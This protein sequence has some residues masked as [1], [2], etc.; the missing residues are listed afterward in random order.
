MRRAAVSGDGLLR[1]V[2]LTAG[3]VAAGLLVCGVVVALW[4]LLKS[5]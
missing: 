1:G 4:A 3:V 5:R 2:E